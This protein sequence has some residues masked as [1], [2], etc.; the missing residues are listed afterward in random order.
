LDDMKSNKDRILETAISLFSVRGF[1]GTS[2]RH[3]ANEMGIS[4]SNIYHH[5]GNKEGVLLA[6]LEQ[7]SERL[8]S[9]LKKA[10]EQD[11][12]PIAKLKRLIE[13][14]L[15][16]CA[17]YTEETKIFF[18][19]EEHLSKKGRKSTAI[20]S[21]KSMD[22]IKSVL[23]ELDDVGLI[24]YRSNKGSGVQH[25]WRHQLAASLVPPMVPFPWNEVREEIVSFI[26]NG[27]LGMVRIRFNRVGF[28]RR[29]FF[30]RQNR[31]GGKKV[32]GYTID[33]DTGGTFTDGFFVSGRPGGAREGA[34]VAARFNHLFSG[35]HQSGRRTVR[36]SVEDLL[37][38]TDIIRFSNTIGTNTI[39]QRD[40][41]RLGLLVTA[42]REGLVPSGKRR[43][44][45]APGGSGNGRGR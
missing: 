20:F 6:I 22:F 7:A 8:V 34:H 25:L 11:L 14:H 43:W 17:S 21:V 9:E 36:V 32:M 35:V 24:H 12:P 27:V 38:D 4:L 44:K 2:I 31:K 29:P 37:Y 19:D 41:S 45:G 13:T 42:G 5:F 10:S 1:H 28:F 15:E 26:M 23:Q 3:I 40:G 30:H 39:I 16:L 33:I 18:L